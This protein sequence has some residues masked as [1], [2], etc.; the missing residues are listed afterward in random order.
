M[1]WRRR[2]GGCLVLLLLG[3][4]LPASA[5]SLVETAGR[6]VADVVQPGRY[7]SNGL[8]AASFSVAGAYDG[9]GTPSPDRLPALGPFADPAWSPDGSRLAYQDEAGDLAVVDLA[10]GQVTSGAPTPGTEKELAWSPDGTRI[11]FRRNSQIWVVDADGTAEHQVTSVGYNGAPSWSPDGTQLVFESTRSGLLQV[12]LID[13]AA[14]E[15]ATQLTESSGVN[16]WPDWAPDGQ[17]IVFVS[18]RDLDGDADLW[19]MPPDASEETQ[20]TGDVPLGEKEPQWSPDGEQIVFSQS[21]GIGIVDRDGSGHRVFGQGHSPD[22]QPL[23]ACTIEGTSGPDQLVGTT[24]ADVICG[25]DGDDVI[26][27]GAG[28]DLLLGGDGRDVVVPDAT[29][30]GLEVD[31][32]VGRIDSA[33]GHD[34]SLMVEDIVGT[35]AADTIIG[36]FDANR[37]VGGPGDDLLGGN[38]GTD[39]IVGGPGEDTF[40]GTRRD[41]VDLDLGAG[42][43]REGNSWSTVTGVENARGAADA[44]VGTL[45]G[46]DRPNVLDSGGASGVVLVGRGG[47]DL[48]VGPGVAAFHEAPAGVTV[49]LVEGTALGDGSDTLVGIA[50]AWGSSYDDTLRGDPAHPGSIFAGAG[51]DLVSNAGGTVTSGGPGSDTADYGAAPSGVVL[52]LVNGRQR[53]TGHEGAISAFEVFLGSPHDDVFLGSPADETMLGADGDDEFQ[54]GGGDDAV[55]GGNGVDLLSYWRLL[56]VVVDLGA[57]TATG[58]GSD[59]MAG[60]EN[61]RGSR[62]D[63]VLVGDDGDNL[64]T[65]AYGDDHV[66]GGPGADLVRGGPDRD[67]LFGG[68]GSDLLEAQDAAPDRVAGGRDVD[69]CSVDPID[70]VRGCRR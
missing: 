30:T 27:G 20:L 15:P 8:I 64:L 63:D 70:M 51:D 21:G 56:A 66:S 10:T 36:D 31:L 42:N 18:G 11:A 12:H 54:P 57:G 2:L 23:P 67:L 4:A 29:D 41:G 62:G 26:R 5:D 3:P 53:G 38:S 58:N 68:P 43:V 52:D 6:R 45:R 1:P 16:R 50:S 61:V 46:D 49:D 47:D 59:T 44:L 34:S 33:T 40:L 60:V 48:L 24:G 19:L 32:R 7:T 28:D 17:S 69:Q 14:G 65:G 37:V 55:D 22:W 13:V 39:E 9:D 35:E 25:G